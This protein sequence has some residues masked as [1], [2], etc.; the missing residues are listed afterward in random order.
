MSLEKG[1]VYF[2]A[3][4]FFEIIHYNVQLRINEKA[5][6]KMHMKRIWDYG[7]N[8]EIQYSL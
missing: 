7:G 2:A 1:N 5:G 3:F 8:V 6:H 4:G